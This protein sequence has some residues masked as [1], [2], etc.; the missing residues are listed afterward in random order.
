[1][2]NCYN[3]VIVHWNVLKYNMFE[4]AHVHANY[5]DHAVQLG[6]FE[7]R[8]KNLV[9]HIFMCKNSRD[10]NR[11]QNCQ[12][13]NLITFRP[14]NRLIVSKLNIFSYKHY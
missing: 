1:M 5:F 7:Q 9:V 3:E 2:N 14:I 13:V 4:R 10:G 11:L 12:P 8:I 6:K